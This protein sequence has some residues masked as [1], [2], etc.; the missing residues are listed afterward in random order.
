MGVVV[1]A[2]T[3]PAPAE[4]VALSSSHQTQWQSSSIKFERPV[5]PLPAVLGV[6]GILWVSSG[7][8]KPGQSETTEGL[9]ERG[10]LGS[11][12]RKTLPMAVRAKKIQFMLFKVNHV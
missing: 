8:Q 12:W 3:A 5:W 6:G 2:L 1:P 4:E 11:L 7:R 10:A 9:M